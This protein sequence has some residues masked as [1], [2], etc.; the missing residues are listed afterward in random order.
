M[1]IPIR[2]VTCNTVIAGKWLK[3]IE[4]VKKERGPGVDD[5]EYLTATTTKSAE[6]KVLDTLGLTKTCCR[7]HFLTH[8][9][10]I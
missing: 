6:G 8:V 5:I 9:D 1:I 3:Y 7:R 10:L 4:L 2:C